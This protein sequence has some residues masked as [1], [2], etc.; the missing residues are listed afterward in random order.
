M[1]S[2]VGSWRNW[3]AVEGIDQLDRLAYVEFFLT[4][5]LRVACAQPTQLAISIKGLT[6]P[7]HA[8][9]LLSLA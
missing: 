7:R 8:K 5:S 2:M 9:S 1:G 4:R 6:L 3:C